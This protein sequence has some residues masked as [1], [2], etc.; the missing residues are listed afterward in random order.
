MLRYPSCTLLA[1]PYR[2]EEAWRPAPPLGSI[3]V[4]RPISPRSAEE[5]QWAAQAGP[6]CSVVAELPPDTRPLDRNGLYDALV[7][8]AGVPAFASG[9]DNPV[10]A[11]LQRRAATREDVA[12][13]VSRRGGFILLGGELLYRW[14]RSPHALA[15]RSARWRIRSVSLFNA[16][17]WDQVARLAGFRLQLDESADT[18]ADRYGTDIRT[19]RRQ[20][21]HCLNVPF[22]DFRSLVGWEWRVEAALRLELARGSRE[23]SGGGGW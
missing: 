1:P 16:G 17:H 12:R 8:V 4:W 23:A 21:Q 9:C 6:W 20:V 22:S 7:T 3:L 18:L 14:T 5:L 10:N 13:Y 15:E 11:V 19:L 2:T